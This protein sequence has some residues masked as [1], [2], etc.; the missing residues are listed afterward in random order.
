MFGAVE[1]LAS[2]KNLYKAVKSLLIHSEFWSLIVVLLDMF[3][4]SILLLGWMS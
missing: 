3:K 4:V 1:G 2:K